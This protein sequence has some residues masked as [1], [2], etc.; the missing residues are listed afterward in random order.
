VGVKREE[1]AHLK[2]FFFFKEREGRRNEGVGIVCLGP[3]FHP[4]GRKMKN[5]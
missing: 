3:G 2:N 4:K 1:N 5:G